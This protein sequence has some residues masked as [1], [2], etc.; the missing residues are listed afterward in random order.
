MNLWTAL[1]THWLLHKCRWYYS[2]TDTVN[3]CDTL[4]MR[5]LHAKAQKQCTLHKMGLCN[6]QRDRNDIRPMLK[7]NKTKRSKTMRWWSTL[8]C[9]INFEF[10]HFTRL[11]LDFAAP[12]K[13]PNTEINRYKYNFNNWKTSCYFMQICTFVYLKLLLAGKWQQTQTLKSFVSLG[14]CEECLC[15]WTCLGLYLSEKYTFY[16]LGLRPKANIKCHQV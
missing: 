9:K 13:I 10:V 14:L 11:T 6:I 7:P 16:S 15:Y 12:D 5:I 1:K 8:K 3:Q 4:P 2:T